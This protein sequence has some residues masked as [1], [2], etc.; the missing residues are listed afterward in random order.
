[1]LVVF[2][3]DASLEIGTGHVMRCLTLA[4]ALD[5]KGVQ[6][7]FVCRAHVGHLENEILRRGHKCVL[8]PLAMQQINFDSNGLAHAAWLGCHW[9][10][11]A[12]ETLAVL[13]GQQVDWLIVDHYALDARWEVHLSHVCRN[14]LAIDD[15]ADRPHLCKILLDQTLGRTNQD[16][17][18]L[19]PVH[20]LRLIGPRYALLRPEF[21]AVRDLSLSRRQK[22]R[23]RQVLV[24]MGGVDQTDATGR[25]LDA[26]VKC[27]LPVDCSLVVVMG[28]KAVW[29]DS[30]RRKACAMPWPTS[31]KVSVQNMAQIMAESDL[32]LGAAGTT[33]WERCCLGLPTI[34]MVLADNQRDGAAA[35]QKAGA[36]IVQ[37][38]MTLDNTLPCLFEDLKNTT[39]LSD[40]SA[41]G[42]R[43]VDGFGV[44]RVV[45]ELLN[46]SLG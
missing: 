43:V 41:S 31:V 35:L 38:D 5:S 7:V 10:A 22:P 46:V 12:E 39:T 24:S 18:K 20:C 21:S 30:I 1:M 45:E 11:D 40:L 28:S 9:K 6:C 16:Y 34:T 8:L 36:V 4:D 44:S 15:L 32:A 26:L 33:A 2:R 27:A 3:A 25:V 29:L 17:E 19:V 37:D 42:A 14:I 13:A 23:I